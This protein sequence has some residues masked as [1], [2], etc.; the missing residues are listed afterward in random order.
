[1]DKMGYDY[2]DFNKFIAE[3]ESAFDKHQSKATLLLDAPTEDRYIK[4]LPVYSPEKAYKH[5]IKNQKTGKPDGWLEVPIIEGDYLET[6]YVVQVKGNS[7]L[8]LYDADSWLILNYTSDY[9][10]AANNICL[11]HHKSIID[12]YEANYTIRKLEVSQFTPPGTLLPVTNILLHDLTGTQSP[13]S[14]FGAN[15]LTDISIIGILI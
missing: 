12:N 14:I 4:Y 11:V 5:F 1:M 15:E 3:A 6:Q 7:L 2:W 9:S 10:L 13:I 8:P